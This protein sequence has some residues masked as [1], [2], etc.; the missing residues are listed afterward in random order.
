MKN[1]MEYKGYIGSVEFSEEDELFF[2]QNLDNKYANTKFKA[3][4]VLLKAVEDDGLDG[5]IVRVGNL[6]SRY[7]DG[8]FQINFVTNNFMR[9]LRAYA[10]LG[11][12]P[13][14]ALDKQVEFS[15]IDCTA[16]AVV[17]LS[18]TD[19][20]YTVFHAT[21]GHRVQMGDV[22][23]AMNRIG[24][25]VKIVSSKEFQDAFNA[26]LSDEKMNEIL[27][28]LISYRSSQGEAAQIFIGH[29]N[30]FTTKMLYHLGVKWP[31][32]NE[33]YLA[34]AFSALEGFGF[35]TED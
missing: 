18:A 11:M 34:N 29:D 9:S 21:N 19:K 12:I 4:Q 20:Q 14:A 7:S 13:V 22:V 35:F 32:I 8:E 31:I 27:S 5:M 30:S 28:P 15:P 33:D 6:M 26:A 25:P 3:E 17:A 2:G 1:T 24:V 16:R 23:E 10:K